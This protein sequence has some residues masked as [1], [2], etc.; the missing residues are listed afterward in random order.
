MST[1]A[2]KQHFLTLD[3]LR[4]TAAFCVLLLHWFD[5]VGLPW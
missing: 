3:F 2:T 5:G 4:G 1:P